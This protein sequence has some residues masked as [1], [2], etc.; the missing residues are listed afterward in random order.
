MSTEGVRLAVLAALAASRTGMERADLLR[1]LSA[2]GV[3]ASAAV[4]VIGTVLGSGDVAARGSVLELAPAGIV[5]LLGLN[6]EIARALDPSPPLPGQEDCPSI[7]WLTSVQT[8]WID[9]LSINYRVDPDA[10]ATL[11]PAPLEVEVHKGRG[12][13]QILMSSLRD[14]R[15]KGMPA[16]LGTCFYQVSYRAAVQYRVDDGSMR[17]GGYFV[18]SETNHPVMRAIGNALAEFKFHAFGAAE[19]V[20]LRDGDRLTAGVDPPPEFP[21]GKL[22]AVVDTRPRAGPPA[23]SCW[24]SLQELHEPLVECYDA[25]GVDGAN[26]YLYV[27]TIDRDPWKARFVAP[28]QIYSEYFDQGPLGHGA[29]E[30]DSVLHL[31]ECRYRWRP[32]RRVALRSRSGIAR[33]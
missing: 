33:Q 16:L 12:W 14:M 17:R 6:A 18:R 23:L 24:S 4:D 11:L 13:V 27:L 8:C 5:A 28:D 9:A 26:G 10:L 20:M 19:M 31:A 7:P 25:L 30:L 1:A 15:P 29:A 21:S 3:D 22:V 2:A 32:L